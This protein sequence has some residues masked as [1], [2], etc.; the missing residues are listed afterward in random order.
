MEY[1]QLLHSYIMVLIP[2]LW[3]LLQAPDQRVT[4]F[5][6]G[7]FEFDPK[8]VGFV[9]DSGKNEFKVLKSDGTVMPG[10]GN[11]GH[12]YG[13]EISDEEKWALVEYMKTL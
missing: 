13:T 11:G 2:N 8:N 12:I 10:N 4:S 6:V 9:S 5:W 7:S 3:Q 1:G